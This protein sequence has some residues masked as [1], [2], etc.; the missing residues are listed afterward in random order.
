MPCCALDRIDLK[1]KYNNDL[2]TI[3]CQNIVLQRGVPKKLLIGESTLKDV[4]FGAYV[5]E[6]AR[7]GDFLGEYIGEVSLKYA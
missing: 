4:G 7:K 1:N 3:G 5:A 2:F 6:D